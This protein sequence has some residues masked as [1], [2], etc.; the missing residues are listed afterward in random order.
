MDMSKFEQNTVDGRDWGRE[1]LIRRL[2]ALAKQRREELGIGRVPFASASSIG[3]D[4][5]VRN[6]EFGKHLP[7]GTTLRKL[8]RAL[9]WRTGSIDEVMS[10]KDRR[11]STVSMS[12][13]DEEPTVSAAGRSLASVPTAELLQEVIA[14]LSA[15]QAGLGGSPE[16]RTL[17]GLAAQGH[18]PEHLEDDEEDEDGDEPEGER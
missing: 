18:I 7:T 6:F 8:E 9:G 16:Y 13:L 2:G 5:T 1:A 4:A 3:S 11:A 15:L 14:R 10:S 12:D 17:Y